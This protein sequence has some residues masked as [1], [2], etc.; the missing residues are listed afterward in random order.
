MVVRGGWWVAVVLPFLAGV[1]CFAD[2]DQADLLGGGGE[3]LGWLAEKII[4]CICIFS[5]FHGFP[6]YFLMALGPFSQIFSLFD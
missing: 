6:G 5:D 3:L 2:I 4:F 1:H